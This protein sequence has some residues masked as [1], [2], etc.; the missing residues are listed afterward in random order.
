MTLAFQRMERDDIMRERFSLRLTHTS[1]SSSGSTGR[2]GKHRPG[3]LDCSVKR[4]NE[5]VRE[6]VMSA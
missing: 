5:C 3:V 6:F 4:G 1:L 2:S